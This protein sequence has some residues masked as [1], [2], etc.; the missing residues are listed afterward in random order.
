MTVERP[1]AQVVGL[2]AEVEPTGLGESR[3]VP[4]LGVFKVQIAVEGL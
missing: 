1:S 4:Q 2:E 3:R